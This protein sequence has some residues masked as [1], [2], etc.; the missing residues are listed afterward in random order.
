M[1]CAALQPR[2]TP[3]SP[4]AAADRPFLVS[5]AAGYPLQV[6]LQREH[7]VSAA[8]RALLETGALEQA[9]RSAA[10][11]LAA[12]PGFHPAIVLQ[13]IVDFGAG[14]WPDAVARLEPVIA[15]LPGYVAA[16][17]VL[18]RTR[19]RLEEIPAAVAVYAA[20][21]DREPLAA[22]SVTRLRPRAVEILGLR[23]EEALQRGRLDLAREALERLEEWAPSSPTTLVAELAV[24]EA[25]GEPERAL[26][27]ARQ[28]A[29]LSPGDE[30][31]AERLAELEL[32]A[33]DAGRGLQ[34]LEELAATD[35]TDVARAERLEEARFRWRLELLPEQARALADRAVLTRGDF[36]T[37]IF[38]L[39]P[40]VRYGR[41]EGATIASDILESPVRREIAR[42]VNLGLLAVDPNLHLFHPER[43]ITRQEALAALL[44][45][46]RSRRPPAACAAATSGVESTEGIC[47]AAQRCGLIADLAD[48]LPGAPLSGAEATS[49]ARH[50]GGLL[51]GA[52]TPGP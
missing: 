39:F 5:P 11:W 17:L 18:G 13:A 8:H 21:A 16:H 38:W 27:A 47:A 25:A 26:A 31:L 15:E 40:A 49:L 37:L 36:A 9:S 32:E 30:T 44:Q 14:R 42:V 28:L 1:G 4:F 29:Q 43:P 41:A 10:Q 34:I 46:V 12:D 48:C 35:P 33:G 23:I 3:P 6:P 2:P 20:V 50:G 7:E 24:G 45:L 22:V 52:E 51:A 19:E